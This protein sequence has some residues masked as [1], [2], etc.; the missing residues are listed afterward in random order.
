MNL[1]MATAIQLPY[2]PSNCHIVMYMCRESDTVCDVKKRRIKE[3]DEGDSEP[4]MAPSI[5]VA[6]SEDDAETVYM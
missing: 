4:Q 2:P 5:P 6:V 3:L 1:L